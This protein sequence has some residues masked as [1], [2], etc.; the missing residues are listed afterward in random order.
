MQWHVSWSWKT[1]E[2]EATNAQEL[3][4]IENLQALLDIKEARFLFQ[5]LERLETPDQIKELDSYQAQQNAWGGSFYGVLPEQTF[6]LSPPVDFCTTLRAGYELAKTRAENQKA[7]VENYAM[8]PT[9][10]CNAPFPNLTQRPVPETWSLTL[11]LEALTRLLDLFGNDI[12]TAREAQEIS[13]LS[14]FTEMIKHRA[15]LGYLPRPWVSAERLG[16][17][18]QQASSQTPLDRIWKWLHPQNF[19]DLAGVYR[20]QDRYRELVETLREHTSEI[21]A[22]ILGTLAAFVPAHMHTRPFIE[23]VCF[24]IGWGIAGW[25]TAAVAGMNIEHFKDDYPR[26][27]TTLTHEL[28]HQ[29]QLHICPLDPELEGKPNEIEDLAAFPFADE[30]DRKFYEI[31]TYL[32]LEGTATHVA[33]S[34]EPKDKAAHIDHGMELLRQSYTA[35]YKDTDLE[36]AEAILNQGLKS[37]GPFYWLGC[38]M[39]AQIVNREGR[40]AVGKWLSTGSPA[41]LKHYLGLEVRTNR[42]PGEAV[43]AKI[44]ALEKEMN[45]IRNRAEEKGMTL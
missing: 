12:A 8:W 42:Y 9:Q 20:D 44:A 36:K 28:F 43:A 32:V 37:N 40:V 7:L 45:E 33:P 26:L 22:H 14:C 34:H 35:L 23:K 27:L 6:A 3:E 19:F 16:H 1:L 13:H 10:F 41:F 5:Q 39:T 31:L 30:R 17:F 4:L 25:A 18:I 21:T 15:S 24:T 38:H 11:E 29:L 2:A